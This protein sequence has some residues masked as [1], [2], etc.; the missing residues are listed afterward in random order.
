MSPSKIEIETIKR[1]ITIEVLWNKL[2]LNK[3]LRNVKIDKVKIK[4]SFKAELNKKNFNYQ[5]F[6]LI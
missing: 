4:K 6:Y 5:K 3:F 1:K 2:I